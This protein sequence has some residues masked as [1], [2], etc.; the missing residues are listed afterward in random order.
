MLGLTEENLEVL[1]H[2]L[3]S[4]AGLYEMTKTPEVRVPVAQTQGCIERLINAIESDDESDTDSDTDSDQHKAFAALWHLT[5]TAECHPSLLGHDGFT[6]TLN[7]GTYHDDEA[8]KKMVYLSIYNLANNPDSHR[9]FIGT[10]AL[11]EAFV[12]HHS[13]DEFDTD[14]ARYQALY[15][16]TQTAECQIPL[17]NTENLLEILI[18]GLKD[19]NASVQ[20]YA[21]QTL[22]ALIRNPDN[23]RALTKKL[24]L[25]LLF[26]QLFSARKDVQDQYQIHHCYDDQQMLHIMRESL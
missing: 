2:L 17:I 18:D 24:D 19:T 1:E 23:H 13:N 10:P 15:A 6:E 11:C 7:M 26:E 20:A 12:D 9:A 4:V 14:L 16:L 8:I 21:Y 25:T 5:Q 22:C 3:L